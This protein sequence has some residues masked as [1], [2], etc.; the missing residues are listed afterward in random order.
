MRLRLF[1]WLPVFTLAALV[2]DL[3]AAADREYTCPVTN[4]PNPS[5]VPPAPYRPNA[6]ARGF[7]YGNN[8]LW[9]QLPVEGVWR[10]LP[11]DNEGY[12]N[13]LFLWQQGFDWRKEPKPDIIVILRRLDVQ[14]PLVSSRG[15]TVALSGTSGI[16]D[17]SAMLTGVLFPTEGCWEVTG[18]HEGHVLTFV[19]SIEP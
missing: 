9:T 5:F 7:W 18:Y 1:L 11:R 10:G 19:L 13:K 3:A 2:T 16:Y 8:A 14:V 4:P 6:G 12:F 17:T 15:G